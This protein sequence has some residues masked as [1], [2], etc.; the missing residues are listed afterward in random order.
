MSTAYKNSDK[1]LL[2]ETLMHALWNLQ[3]A[4]AYSI[5]ED[6]CNWFI[7]ERGLFRQEVR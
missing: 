3:A 1:S 2:F 7:P 4:I 6:F 5:W